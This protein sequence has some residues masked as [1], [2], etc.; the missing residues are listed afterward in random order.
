M[1]DMLLIILAREEIEL[2]TKKKHKTMGQYL[3]IGLLTRVS[4]DATKAAK[5]K[6]SL[7]MASKKL[8]KESGLL[9]EHYEQTK[10]DDYWVWTL[11][12]E[13]LA[14]SL[15]PFLEEFYEAY[16][17]DEKSDSQDVL[18]ALRASSLEQW[19]QM[20]EDKKFYAFQ[21]DGYGHSNYLYFK[22]VDFRPSLRWSFD[23]IMLASAGKILMEVY[24]DMFEFLSHT[25]QHRFANSPLGG[26][27]QIY[28]T[29]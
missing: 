28:I 23:A 12:K 26:A 4:I 20:A 27:L 9:L 15:I 5:E 16:Y 17:I 21:E 19:L 6:I 13:V 10:E 29:G 11:K 2:L 22:D 25:I 18:R 24:N 14:A 1:I 3:S 8:Q 7:E